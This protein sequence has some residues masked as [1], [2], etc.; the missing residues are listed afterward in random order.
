MAYI[1]SLF[2]LVFLTVVFGF[3]FAKNPEKSRRF[4]KKIFAG[5]IALFIAIMVF[6]L[7][8][9]VPTTTYAA[10]DNP[11]TPVVDT[12]DNTGLGLIGAA[13]ATGLAAVGAG[14]GVGMVGAA[15]VGAISEKPELLGK[16]LIYVGLAEG[17]AIYGLIVTIM[18]LGRI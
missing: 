16:T 1:I 12:T 11:S 10:S 6:A 17:I 3:Y 4:A 8:S 9:L 18:I 15:S 14:V 5:N 13:L 7:I 2:I